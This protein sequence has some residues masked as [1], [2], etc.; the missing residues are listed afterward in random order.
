MQ[1]IFLKHEEIFFSLIHLNIIKYTQSLVDY[2][3]VFSL[4]N[5]FEWVKNY[6]II[7]SRMV[8]NIFLTILCIYL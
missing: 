5:I 3:C 2:F 4:A 7:L 8:K 1:L 6:L